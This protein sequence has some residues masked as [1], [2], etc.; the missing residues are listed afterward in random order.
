M[1]IF[2]TH[3]NPVILDS[4]FAPVAAEY[5]WT[6]DLTMMDFTVAPLNTLEQIICPSLAVSVNGFEFVLPAA[7]KILVFDKETSQL[8][9]VG[10]AEAAGKE[11]TAMVYGPK[12]STATA[13]VITVTNYF[14]EYVNVNPSLNKHQMMCHPISADEWI[15]VSPSDPYNKYLKDCCVGDLI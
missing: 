9:V 3:Y 6:L 7:W 13:A 11:F 12:L 10:V 14:P 8:D 15:S 5:F 1:L 2:D 4:I